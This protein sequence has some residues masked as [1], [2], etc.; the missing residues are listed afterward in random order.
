MAIKSKD[1]LDLSKCSNKTF[2]LC[3][4]LL[5]KTDHAPMLYPARRW[6]LEFEEGLRKG[7]LIFHIATDGKRIRYGVDWFTLQQSEPIIV[8]TIEDLEV[9]L[10]AAELMNQ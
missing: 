3:I 9:V 7:H 1:Y 5:K 10:F 6:F 4:K 2:E 8:K